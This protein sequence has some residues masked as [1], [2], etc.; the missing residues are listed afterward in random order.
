MFMAVVLLMVASVL[1]FRPGGMGAGRLLGRQQLMAVS[2]NPGKLSDLPLFR[3]QSAAPASY[4]SQGQG[5]GEVGAAPLGHEHEQQ[6]Q[7]EARRT[8]G[9][10]Q[11]SFQQRDAIVSDVQS[12][13]VVA[14]PGAGKTRVLS[15]RMAYLLE[16]GKCLP[17]EILALS[18]TNSAAANIK[19]RADRLL[20]G[21]IATT[22][23]MTV[24]TFHGLCSSILRSNIGAMRADG[25]EMKI[26]DDGEQMKIMMSLLESSGLP[27]SHITATNTLRQ[28]R[29]WKELGLGYLGVRK[30]S[31]TTW[32]EQ[33]AYEL[34]PDYQLP[35]YIYIYI[36][37]RPQR[38]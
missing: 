15:A 13:L 16:S 21:S 31:L 6:R 3:P 35:I 29:Y 14:G 32:T 7:E 8:A 19:M 11:P 20:S 17:S 12:V 36:Y 2:T 10:N 9:S 37:I 18:Y 33:R 23:G 1:A 27:A 4:L 5:P 34:Y 30:N 24:N 26:A 38:P 28:I 22:E 25:R